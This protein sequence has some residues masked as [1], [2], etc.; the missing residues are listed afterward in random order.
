MLEMASAAL[1]VLVRVTT[2][3]A[4]VVFKVWLENDKFDDDKT[5]IGAG[6]TT[7]VPLRVIVCGLPAA[8]SAMV[9]AAIRVPVA[10]GVN[11]TLIVQFPLFEGTELPQVLVCAKSPLFV[12]VKPMLVMF[13][14]AFPVSVS[15]IVCD[16]LVVFK[17][18][19][20]N[21]SVEPE[22]LTTGKV[23]YPGPP[24]SNVPNDGTPFVKSTSMYHRLLINALETGKVFVV[25]RVAVSM[26][27]PESETWT[28]RPSR[29]CCSHPT[30]PNGWPI[31][32]LATNCGAVPGKPVMS[33]T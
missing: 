16:E 28:N 20:A 32:M 19:L 33:Y 2:C 23:R 24:R 5:S 22:R 8:S 25:V 9:T 14:A 29:L 18:W 10:V 1:P 4:L 6:G 12:P 21:V 15:V 17:F 11:V 30:E 3:A 27:S 26:T 31:L 7:P 13:N